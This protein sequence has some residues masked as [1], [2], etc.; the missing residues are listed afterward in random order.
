MFPVSPEWWAMEVMLN[1]WTMLAQIGWFMV[2]M[3]VVI[4][5]RDLF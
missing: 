2:A 1:F 4:A 5:I 3:F